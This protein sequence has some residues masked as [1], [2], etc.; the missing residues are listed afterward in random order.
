MND[1]STRTQ[2]SGSGEVW[3]DGQLCSA[4]CRVVAPIDLDLA[5]AAVPDETSRFAGFAGDCAG[6]TCSIPAATAP[7]VVFA[8]F[9]SV[10]EWVRSF[11]IPSSDAVTLALA[12]DQAGIGVAVTAGRSLAVE[13]VTYQEPFI[14]RNYSPYVLDMDLDGGVRWVVPLYDTVD[15]GAAYTGITATA[16]ARAPAGAWLVA[17]GCSQGHFG[18]VPC[19]TLTSVAEA[20][21]LV[22]VADAGVR[23][24]LLRGDLSGAFGAKFLE[25][26]FLASTA[27]LRFYRFQAGALWTEGFLSLDA[28]WDAGVVA[29]AS[30]YQD[31]GNAEATSVEGSCLPAGEAL[32][33][34]GAVTG[35]F[36]GLGCPLST[37]SGTGTDLAL[38]RFSPSGQCDLVDRRPSSDYVTVVGL[39]RAQDG[40]LNVAGDAQGVLQFGPGL[41]TGPGAALADQWIAT[42]D[43]GAYS[44]LWTSTSTS[45]AM[46]KD[47][48]PLEGRT[49]VLKSNRPGFLRLGWQL[50][51]S[52]DDPDGLRLRTILTFDANGVVRRRW[53]ILSSLASREELRLGHMTRVG[54]LLIVPSS[55]P[56]TAF[57]ASRLRPTCRCGCS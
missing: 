29:E 20:P 48:L 4:P 1:P 52:S 11:P 53:P 40:G 5:V 56:G 39:S 30:D 32:L 7:V 13:G 21:L 2:G 34:A 26:D 49:L 12:A 35:D 47:V 16:L 22:E 55:A 41:S 25:A 28:N 42:F 51:W 15:A 18:G 45:F 31:R 27:L 14:N 37:S 6:D 24:F 33:C 43:R 46:L 50:V 10:L 36:T 23:R 8:E 19:G 44:Q 3:V 17:G 54:D 38:F 57:A 9:A